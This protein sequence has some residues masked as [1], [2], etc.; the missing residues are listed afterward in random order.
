MGLSAKVG[1]FNTGTGAATTTVV[2]N[3]VGFQPKVIFFWWNGR[4]ETTDASGRADQKRGFGAAVSATD[5]RYITS[6]S[7]DTPTAMLTNAMQGNAACIGITTTAD[8]IDGLMDL[9]SMDSGGF[10]LVVDDQFTASY[11]VHYL[12]LGGSD[13]TNVETGQFTGNAAGGTGNQDV[14]SLS[15]QPDFLMM[16]SSGQTTANNTVRTDS[17]IMMGA[18]SGASNQA[19]WAGGSN[20]GAGTSQAMS[21]CRAGEIIAAFNTGLTAT[22]DRALFDGFLSN[23]FSLDWS[24]VT[25]GGAVYFF[26]AIKGGQFRVENLL[27]QTDTSTAITETGFGFAPKGVLLVSAGKAA[28]A[29]D[30][31]SDD[32]EWSMG[33]FT[34][35]SA[36]VAMA[37]ADDD[38]AGTAI[39]SSSVSHDE[40]YQNLNAN[41]GAIEGEM[42]VQSVDSDGF[43]LIMDDADPA[44]AF[45]WY[46]A[47][48]QTLATQSNSGAITPTGA[49]TKQA[50]KAVSGAITPSG[51]VT[52]QTNKTV[53]GGI[54]PAG[55][56]L[57]QAAKALSGV[58][59]SAGALV[60][61]LITGKSVSGTVTSAGT[62]TK[63]AN[64]ALSG[65]LAS[66]GAL[67]TNVIYGK[68]VS[69]TVTSAGTLV[70]QVN[71]VVSGA[72]ASA[73]A[74]VTNLIT[75][76]S[77]SGSV[78]PTGTL[79]KQTNK[80]LAGTITPSGSL[81][82][83]FIPGGGTTYTQSVSGTISSS[84]TL[85][86]VFV[87][88]APPSTDVSGYD[89][90]GLYLSEYQ[91]PR[92]T[93]QINL[94]PTAR[95]KR[96]DEEIL[97]LS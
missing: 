14:T 44:Q 95:Q 96:E 56:L 31:P 25:T 12:A 91:R 90:G 94:V 41:T 93:T 51:A 59:A 53:S 49:L 20:D 89:G 38:A 23:G 16:F 80:S 54:T 19:V 63:Q 82:T 6:L 48:G 30:T 4:T 73:G 52:K 70:K 57:K 97:I 9:Q 64:K 2:I 13:I 15:Y 76:K 3:D 39:V 34:S 83:S 61:N 60:T 36:R 29:S 68:S 11:R 55:T 46:A 27:T 45:V 79:A 32:D 85:T 86:T 47:F 8:A 40:V 35:T 43:T 75:A 88:A 81:T 22:E 21:Y 66:A 17:R 58:V 87:P 78:T 24:E 65:A 26:V 33:A 1:S 42:D 10:T 18:A 37:V 69:G 28:D 84:G 67:V 7:Q 50:N 71:K 92:E 62:L 77:N 72:V 5:R 74:L